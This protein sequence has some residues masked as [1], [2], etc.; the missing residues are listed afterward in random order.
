MGKGG[1]LAESLGKDPEP[2]DNS[3]T[4]NEAKRKS[5]SSGDESQAEP[6]AKRH[7]VR[8]NR[9]VELFDLIF[10]WLERYRWKVYEVRGKPL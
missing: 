1:S 6:E 9:T 8:P 2:E 10:R 7:R 3:G 5:A 4:S